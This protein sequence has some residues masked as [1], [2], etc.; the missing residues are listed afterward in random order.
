VLER[1]L[2]AAKGGNKKPSRKGDT[3]G[4]RE[5]VFHWQNPEQNPN[6]QPFG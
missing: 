1:F 2:A 5:R 4:S 6:L 3:A